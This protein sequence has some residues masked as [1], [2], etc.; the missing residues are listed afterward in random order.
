MFEE[1]F[2]CKEEKCN[3]FNLCT[4]SVVDLAVLLDEELAV[5]EHLSSLDIG[6]D[7]VNSR[8]SIRIERYLNCTAVGVE[9]IT[10]FLCEIGIQFLTPVFFD[11]NIYLGQLIC[12]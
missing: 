3:L 1:P 9:N 6:S 11:I 10:I 7:I 4:G 2:C 12:T 8:S 5:A